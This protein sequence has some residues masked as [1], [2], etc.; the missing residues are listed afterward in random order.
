MKILYIII[1]LC[2]FWFTNPLQTQA[3]IKGNVTDQDGKPLYFANIALLNLADS[4]FINAT[5]SDDKGAF[6][7]TS[8]RKGSFLLNISHIAYKRKTI[9]LNISDTGQLISLGYIQLEPSNISLDE[10]VVKSQKP[11]FIKEPD[12]LIFN[13]D[14]STLLSTQINASEVLNKLPGVWIDRQNNISLN[15]QKNI[16]LTINGRNTFLTG[17]DLMSMLRSI[18]A[19]TIEKIEIIYNPDA[20]YNAEGVAIINIKTKTKVDTGFKGNLTSLLGSSVGYG[21]SY[22]RFNSGV[23]LSFG[24]KKLSIIGNYNYGTERSLRNINEKLT[25]PTSTLEQS[26]RLVTTPENT[27]SLQTGID[28]SPNQKQSIRFFYHKNYT[29]TPTEQLNSINLLDTKKNRQHINSNSLENVRTNQDA[30]NFEFQNHIDSTKTLKFGSDYLILS[31]NQNAQYDNE[32]RNENGYLLNQ[33]LDNIAETGIRVW[34]N[35]LDFSQKINSNTKFEA[36]LKYSDARTQNGVDFRELYDKMWV[37]DLVRSNTFNYSEKLFATYFNYNTSY[38]KTNLI[39]GLRYEN[40][41]IAG[42][43][44]NDAF[45]IERRFKGLFPSLSI[46][47]AAKQNL[48]LG[49]FYSRRIKRPGYID[50]NPYIYYVNPFTALEGNPELIPSI[51]DKLQLNLQL[52]KMYSASL[53][54]YHTN[55]FFTTAQFQNVENQTQRLVPTNIGTLSNIELNIGAPFNLLKWWESYFDISFIHQ[56]YLEKTNINLSFLQNSR[57]TFQFFS[58]HSFSLPK[59]ISL[60]L[61]NTLV[62]PS[63][64]GQF[65]FAT[66]YTFSAGLKK[67]FFDK[68]VDLKIGANDFLRTMKYVGTLHGTNWKSNYSDVKDWR[69][70][71]ISLNYNFYSKGKIKAN[72]PNWI[73]NEEKK[74]MK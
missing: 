36:G 35:N 63:I 57:Y 74:R 47:Y 61:T 28:F 39:A 48:D 37:Q 18:P 54:Y 24:T 68:K 11:S 44:E 2:L 51:T 62:T 12:R 43:S 55:N 60:E 9:S 59:D 52:D 41:Q 1:G 45:A 34:V 5:S 46:N 19:N 42:R 15:G 25:F 33:K 40:A 73:S 16:Q 69:Q 49:F 23:N 32:F 31:K 10:T 7:I 20:K 13:V 27:Q 72:T 21:D 56:K 64:D 14:N 58:Q 22:P 38:K 71:N 17:N 3:Q 53:T 50:I 29:H 70:V 67:S 66:I 4:S 8:S 26:I 6:Q 30:F 65:S